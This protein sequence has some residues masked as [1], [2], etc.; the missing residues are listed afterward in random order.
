[1]FEADAFCSSCGVARGSQTLQMLSPTSGS[2]VR[3]KDQAS[4]NPGRSLAVSSDEALR[5]TREMSRWWAL[6]AL[7]VVG[8]VGWS[9][10][11][12]SESVVQD[13]ARDRAVELDPSPSSTATG[14]TTAGDTTAG[15]TATADTITVE[16]GRGEGSVSGSGEQDS[17]LLVDESNR[18]AALILE[19]PI[20]FALFVGA[21]GRTSRVIDLDSG[22]VIEVAPMVGE[23][24]LVT[25]NFLVGTTIAGSPRFLPLDNLGADSITIEGLTGGL[26]STGPDRDQI[27]FSPWDRGLA[28]LRHLVDIPSATILVSE[29]LDRDFWPMTGGSAQLGNVLGSGVYEMTESGVRRITDGWLIA[30]DN[31]LMLVRRCDDRLRCRTDWIDR[32]RGV[33]LDYPDPAMV[34]LE[35]IGAGIDPSSQW[36]WSS[37]SQSVTITQ[38]RT[39]QTFV[40]TGAEPFQQI[41]FSPDGQWLAYVDQ[42]QSKTVLLHLATEQRFHLEGNSNGPLVFLPQT[43]FDEPDLAD[44]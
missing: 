9:L 24:L 27:W 12:T 4:L 38:I 41:A 36:L 39:G 22:R 25:E 11:S 42:T 44:G 8:L 20:G 34:G 15:D 40:L 7:L 35:M 6:V 37:D 31:T 19:E 18:P 28:S 3:A 10:T 29:T 5:T 1:M 14:D 30:A 43:V 26:I 17:V 16:G 23:Q 13:V 2:G 21:S 32:S 33:A